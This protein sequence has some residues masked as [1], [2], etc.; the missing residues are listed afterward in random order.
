MI[1]YV[2]EEG[3]DLVV[4]GTRGRSGVKALLLGTQAERIVDHTP[5]SVLLIK[6][7]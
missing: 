7:K 3:A 2:E 6:P 5:V 1:E 4:V